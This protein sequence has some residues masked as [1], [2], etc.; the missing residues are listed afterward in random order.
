MMNTIKNQGAGQHINIDLLRGS[1]Y[2]IIVDVELAS[3]CAVWSVVMFH[4]CVGTVVSWKRQL[5]PYQGAGAYV[6]V[7]IIKTGEGCEES[8]SMRSFSNLSL[9]SCRLL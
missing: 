3:S 4:V 9:R 8:R 2:A 1:L 7:P 5:D 6:S